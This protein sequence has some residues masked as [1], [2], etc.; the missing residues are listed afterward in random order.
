MVN[1]AHNLDFATARDL[2]EERAAFFSLGPSKFVTEGVA[3]L[4]ALG[5]VS[6]FDCG[7]GVVV[8][9]TAQQMATPRIVQDLRDNYTQAPINSV[10]YTHGHVDHATGGAAILEHSSGRGDPRPR[11]IAHKA[12]PIRFDRYKLLAE[13]NDNINRIQ[14]NLPPSARP[15]SNATFT[16]PDTVHDDGTTIK[17]GDTVFELHHAR[18]ETDDETWV[19]CPS[20]RV[21]CTGDTFV[22][23]SPNAGNPYKVQRYAKDWANALEIMAA[24]KPLHLL[25]GHGPAM[26]GES[27][28]EEALL[29]T[30]HL[31]RSIHDQVVA[32]MNQGKWL[33]DIIRDMDWP[34]TDKPW[35]QPIY[36]HPEFIA[37]NVWR[38]YGGWYDGDPANMLPAHS[39]EVAAELL[40][41]A[42]SGPILD[43][44][45]S[46]RDRGELQMACHLVDFVRKGE[47]DNKQA[48]EL[49]RDLFTA[50][51]EAERSLMARGAFYAAIREADANL[52]RLG[53]G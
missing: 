30:A 5:N 35:L 39:H 9:D 20:R 7:D 26:E 29:S 11:F 19:W 1:S 47:P 44:A 43:R 24:L 16:Y 28:I 22:W 21:L 34:A 53:S 48:W 25:P 37:R 45:R 32:G 4:P 18:G 52:Q 23:C 10:V 14:F 46:L 51:A 27:R 6:A 33:E 17:V 36:D 12:L 13:Q 40:A 31:L 2:P 50:R 49:W 3:F 38:L 15:F 8:V 41:A 42:G